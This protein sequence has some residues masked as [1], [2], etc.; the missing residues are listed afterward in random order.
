MNDRIIQC[1]KCV[2][3]T[4][5]PDIVFNIK[6]I[7]N[8]CLTASTL[9]SSI[10][11]SKEESDRRLEQLANKIKSESSGNEYDCIIGLS[12]GVDSS[13]VA[14][15][16]HRMG[17]N[18][19][20]VHFDNGWN[21]ETA[22]ANIKKIVEHC[23]YDLHT[24]VI[25]WPEFRDLQ[26]A[27]IKASV[28]DIEMLTDHAIMAAM[29]KLA[30]EYNIR[31][32]LSGTNIATEYGMPASWTWRKQDIRN[33]KAI[34][35]RF[36]TKKMKNFPTMSSLKWNYILYFSQILKFVEPLNN[37]EY[38]K[39]I[40]K[41]VLDKEFGWRDYGGKH[42][43]SLFTKFYQAYI[44][45]EKFGIDKRKVH[46]SALIRNGEITR[47]EGMK[48]LSL[49]LYIPN[50]LQRDKKYVLKKLGFTDDEFQN[51]MQ[52]APKK[53]TDYPSDEIILKPLL[54]CGRIMRKLGFIKR[55]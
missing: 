13:Y 35:K 8:Y 15:L 45:P 2:M 14:Y 25:D 1:S 33:I 55:R 28:V 46:L 26:R 40:A 7:C 52:D 48:M 18:P 21:T 34:H 12:G 30:K 27:F 41:K 10:Q 16:A 29:F 31:N 54:Y 19:L 44:L 32:V 50:E 49:P 36:G 53:H 3:D 42:Y 39:T 20:A 38:K 37:I 6:G 23:G 24:Y 47:S 5:D 9:L 43:E 22:V 11:C 51:I 4:T 17:L